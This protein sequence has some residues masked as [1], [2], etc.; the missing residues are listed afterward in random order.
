MRPVE[1][2]EALAARTRLTLFS[3]D[4]P[5]RLFTIGSLKDGRLDLVYYRDP[6]LEVGDCRYAPSSS[7]LLAFQIL[8]ARIRLLC[9]SLYKQDLRAYPERARRFF[10]SFE[11]LRREQFEV[12]TKAT[13]S[14]LQ[15]LL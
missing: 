13:I 1:F 12:L 7:A 14:R 11:S 10:C 15:L 6:D 3:D 5:D 8:A 4:K 2:G 9:E